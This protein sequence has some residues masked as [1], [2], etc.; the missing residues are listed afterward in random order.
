VKS[1]FRIFLI[2]GLLAN[3][4]AAAEKFPVPPDTQE[5]DLKLPTPEESL[6][7]IALPKGF[8]ATVAENSTAGIKLA[9]VSKIPK[10]RQFIPRRLAEKTK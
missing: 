3:S 5:T 7:G 2:C 8:Q 6:A 4:Q 1:P 10:L 9:A